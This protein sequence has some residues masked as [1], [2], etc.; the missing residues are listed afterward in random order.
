MPQLETKKFMKILFKKFINCWF[1]LFISTLAQAQ[2]INGVAYTPDEYLFSQGQNWHYH[3]TTANKPK[4]LN[5]RG[6]SEDEKE[7]V[8]TAQRLLVTTSAKSI[9]LINGD[10]VV[11]VG[12]KPPADKEVHLLSQS[13][14]KTVTSMAVGKAICQGKFSLNSVTEDLVPELRGT[15]LGKSTVRNLLMMTSGTW[16]KSGNLNTGIFD[17]EQNR[18]IRAGRLSQLDIIQKFPISSYQNSFFSTGKSGESFYYHATDPLTLG[19]II[20]K[21]TGIEFA[22]WVEKEVLIPAGIKTYGIIGRDKFGYGNADAGIRLTMEDWVRFAIWVK[23]SQVAN[24]CFGDYVR[25]A[26]TTQISNHTDI[27]KSFGGYG[28]LIWTDNIRLADSYWAIGYGGQRI[29]W[30]HKN[31][32]IL[33]VFSNLENF[34]D[35]LYGLYREWALLPDQK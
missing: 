23:E 4:Q 8:E 5:F 35:N 1:G 26:S 10:D 22:K 34:M 3:T 2:A 16:H 13:I 31:N 9:A 7:I 29:A 27:G 33:V 21:T 6:P 14:A 32:R 15:D 24:G 11:W 30:N 18:A 28:Y 25:A 19:I 12:Y 20:N 17:E